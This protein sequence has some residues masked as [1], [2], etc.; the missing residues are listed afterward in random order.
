MEK[1]SGDTPFNR[2]LAYWGGI[3]AF[4]AFAVALI[5]L[6]TLVRGC[7]SEPSAFTKEE[8]EQRES[9]A[10]TAKAEQEAL[11]G[12]AA[13]KKNEDGTFSVPADVA[14]SKMVET[15]KKRKQTKSSVPVEAA[16][17]SADAAVT[18]GGTQ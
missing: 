13:W 12:D 10:Q 11:V 4:A 18:E 5:V 17:A 1:H 16:A 6:M 3:L 9:W 2:F 8:I 7:S 14:V 15:L